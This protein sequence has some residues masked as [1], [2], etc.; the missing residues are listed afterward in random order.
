LHASAV[1]LRGEGGGLQQVRGSVSGGGGGR[2][3]RRGRERRRRERGRPAWR[4]HRE[5]YLANAQLTLLWW[6][7]CRLEQR[8]LLLHHLQVRA[9]AP[10]RCAG[11]AESAEKPSLKEF[12][13]EPRRWDDLTLGGGLEPDRGTLTSLAASSPVQRHAPLARR[14]RQRQRSVV[15][16]HVRAAAG[17]RAR[18]ARRARVRLHQQLCCCGPRQHAQVGPG[19]AL[20]HQHVGAHQPA[21]LQRGAGFKLKSALSGQTVSRRVETLIPCACRVGVPGCW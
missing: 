4:S 11:D 2:P 3:R 19:V 12:L 8:G 17:W 1:A 10:V 20:L 6:G 18:G 13:A 7:R 5:V 21:R 9:G 16:L 15:R 14:G